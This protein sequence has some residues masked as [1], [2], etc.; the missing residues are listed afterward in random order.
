MTS[1]YSSS[2][3][4]FRGAT[5]LTHDENDH[6][7]P[8]LE[9]DV[10]TCDHLIPDIAQNILPPSGDTE[11]INCKG[12][13]ISPGFVDTHHHLWQTQLKGRH[14]EHGLVAYMYSGA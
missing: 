12:K 3:I 2:S 6:V 7:V 8:L 4:L 14:A 5:V 9:T 10:L 1:N 11:V 13:I